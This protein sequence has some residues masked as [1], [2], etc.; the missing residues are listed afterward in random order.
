MNGKIA[1]AL[2]L[3][4]LSGV[5][6]C[7][8]GEPAPDP[9]GPVGGGGPDGTPESGM[10]APR[11]YYV[12]TAGDDSASG[13]EDEPL[14]T[15]NCALG[16]VAPG[17][18][19]LVRGGSYHEFVRPTVSGERGR[20][21]TLAAC[22]GETVKIDGT[23]LEISGWLQA[24]VRVEVDYM[25]FENLHVCH[26]VNAAPNSD[27]EGFYICGSARGITLR[28][29][30]V[31]DIRN[32]SLQNSSEDWRSAHAILAVG[33][34]D[35]RPI[36]DLLID[37]CEVF[38]ICSGTSES[39]TIAGNVDGFM[40]CNSRVHDVENI[41]IIVAGGE[42]LNPGGDVAVNYARNG[43]IRDNRVYNCTHTKSPEYWGPDRYGAIGIYVCGGSGTVVERNVVYGCDRGI[44]LVSE[45][46]YRPTKDCIVRNNF[47]YNCNRTA[48]YMGDYLNF[49]G[50]GT[51]GCCVI[52]N[53]VYN[54]NAVRGGLGEEDGEGEIRL[55]ENCTD[56]VVMNNIVYARP[57]RDV[58]IRKYTQTGS[59]NVIDYNHYYTAGTPK[60]IW[61]D[62]PYDDYEAWK[63]ASGCD[64]H[65]VYGVDPMLVNASPEAADLHLREHSPAR[66]TGLFLSV[67][68]NGETD[69]DG[70][71]RSAGGVVNKGADQ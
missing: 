4:L 36:R 61:D 5:A 52:N 28:G 23:G 39:V 17:D 51:H 35:N 53:T 22:P 48:I 32:T 24:L 18:T 26:A 13:T 1:M 47:V 12:S 57:E 58:F 63:A 44:G 40:V 56:N 65:S 37:G 64:A 2:V 66:N 46:D 31:Y 25:T 45:C 55:T 33:T 29:C 30:K 38:D 71:P 62:V 14:R 8:A 49:Y 10:M 67:W 34:D 21:I 50:A 43:V 41:G 54:N 68:F 11:R 7:G 59:D 69:I 70:D 60:W 20:V 9:S 15:I 42:T 27:P 6:S 19:V 3:A 16:R